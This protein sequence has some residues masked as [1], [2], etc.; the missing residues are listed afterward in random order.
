MLIKLHLTKQSEF[1][2]LNNNLW[3]LFDYKAA[4]RLTLDIPEDVLFRWCGV[5]DVESNCIHAV[6]LHHLLGVQ[7]VVFRLAH[8]LPRHL[9]T[10]TTARYRLLSWKRRVRSQR[11][12][13]AGH[14]F[15]HLQA[16]IRTCET[17]Y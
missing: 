3:H 8:L 14:S 10:T 17:S 12:E 13:I 2:I 5:K 9:Y 11:S 16:V 7:T 6:L 15:C 4:S 1:I